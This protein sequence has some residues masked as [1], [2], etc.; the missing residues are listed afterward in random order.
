[1]SMIRI[2]YSSVMHGP[3]FLQELKKENMALLDSPY[4]IWTMAVLDI[5]ITIHAACVV[6]KPYD[7]QLNDAVHT[8]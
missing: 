3:R 2:H 5:A 1:M 4:L 6:P 7:E 8:Q